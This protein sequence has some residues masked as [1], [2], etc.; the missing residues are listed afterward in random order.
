VKFTDVKLNKGISPSI[1]E[2]KKPRGY[3]E[4]IIPL[5]PLEST[6]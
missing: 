4:E 5:P 1:F 3:H 6:P 2:I